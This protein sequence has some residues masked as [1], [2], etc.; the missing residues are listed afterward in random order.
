MASKQEVV[1]VIGRLSKA[2]R[3]FNPQSVEAMKDQVDIWAEK[4]ARFPAYIVGQAGEFA[5]ENSKFFPALAEMLADCRRIYA[6]EVTRLNGDWLGLRDP[7]LQKPIGQKPKRAEFEALADGWRRI[8]LTEQA[9]FALYF[10]DENVDYKW[11]PPS[12]ERL[13]QYRSRLNAVAQ[14]MSGRE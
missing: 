11:Q 6:D 12:P 1:S 9:E 2:F 3:N 14:K 13:A 5:I 10:Y 4:L 8:G 7:M